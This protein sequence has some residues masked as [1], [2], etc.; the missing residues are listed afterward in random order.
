MLTTPLTFPAYEPPRLE[1]SEIHE[2]D[3]KAGPP[4]VVVIIVALALIALIGAFAVCIM[5]G[6]DGVA[7]QVSIDS[8]SAKLGCYRN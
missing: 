3:H 4:V 7:F 1:M 2:T 8:W 5:Y 6:Y